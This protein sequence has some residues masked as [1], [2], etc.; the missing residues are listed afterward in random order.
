MVS[1]IIPFQETTTLRITILRRS[2]SRYYGAPRQG[3][4]NAPLRFQNVVAH[5]AHGTPRIMVLNGIDER[6]MFGHQLRRIT[7]LYARQADPDKT[8]RLVD[9][10][11]C[12]DGHSLIP[13]RMRDSCMKTT[14]IFYE[15]PFWIMKSKFIERF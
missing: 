13:G 8:L 4:Q 12:R 6:H 14:I 10:I 7:P 1:K 5:D 11:T 9:R 3:G 15:I 2:A